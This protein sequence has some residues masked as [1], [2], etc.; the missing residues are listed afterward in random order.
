[1][2]R[3]STNDDEVEYDYV[4]QRVRRVRITEPE[5]ESLPDLRQ[6]LPALSWCVNL[7]PAPTATVVERGPWIRHGMPWPRIEYPWLADR[8]PW[9]QPMDGTLHHQDVP[10]R[11]HIV[12]EQHQVAPEQPAQGRPP[13]DQPIVPGLAARD[14]IWDNEIWHWNE[15]QQM[16]WRWKHRAFWCAATGFGVW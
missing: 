5:D 4:L 14:I 12:P 3:S 7:A 10:E 11:R 2:K 6:Q 13:T 16:F 15:E 9:D 8:D 1:M